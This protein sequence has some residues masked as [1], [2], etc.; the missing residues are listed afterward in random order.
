MQ[1]TNCDRA[2]I[3]TYINGGMKHNPQT[4]SIVIDFVEEK[5]TERHAST[6]KN[7]LRLCCCINIY[8]YY[9]IYMKLI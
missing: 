5:C 6:L 4:N 1:I 7:I 8:G 9:I 2:S 3:Y